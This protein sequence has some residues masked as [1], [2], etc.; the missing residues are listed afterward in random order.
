MKA[1]DPKMVAT[2]ICKFVG[3]DWYSDALTLIDAIENFKGE[4]TSLQMA[5]L[6]QVHRYLMQL[7]DDYDE[8]TV[9]FLAEAEKPMKISTKDAASIVKAVRS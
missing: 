3:I 5:K 8:W 7:G 2:T 6:A 1:I 4:A 9:A